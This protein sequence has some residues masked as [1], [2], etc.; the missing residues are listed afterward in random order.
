ME[1]DSNGI[2]NIVAIK[3]GKMKREKNKMNGKVRHK[4]QYNNYG[5]IQIHFERLATK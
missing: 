2:S 5:N 4:Q 3:R 1:Y